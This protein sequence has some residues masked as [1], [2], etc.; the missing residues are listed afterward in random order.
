MNVVEPLTYI[1]NLSLST[2]IVANSTTVAKT[3]PTFTTGPKQIYLIISEPISLLPAYAKIL[4]NIVART[5]TSFLVRHQ[6]TSIVTNMAYE[7]R[8]SSTQPIVRSIVRQY[9]KKTTNLQTVQPWQYLLILV[10]RLTPLVTI[11]S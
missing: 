1:S 10:K 4:E 11:Y 5:V 7:Q 8:D 6:T 3:V 2:G 9:D